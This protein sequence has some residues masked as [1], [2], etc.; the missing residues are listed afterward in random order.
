[1]LDARL[2][3]DNRIAALISVSNPQ[4]GDIIISSIHERDGDRLRIDHEM[5][6][7]AEI[8]GSPVDR[9]EATPAS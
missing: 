2:L 7:E 5:V 3:N 4:T 6:V 1:V 8:P 9:V